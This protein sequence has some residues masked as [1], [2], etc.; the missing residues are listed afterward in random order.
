[1]WYRQILEIV[2]FSCLISFGIRNL[3]EKMKIPFW[4]RRKISFCYTIATLM[5]SFYQRQK[6]AVLLNIINAS[7][8]WRTLC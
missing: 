4:N 8:V 3:K 1:M 6:K 5:D 2:M 7:R